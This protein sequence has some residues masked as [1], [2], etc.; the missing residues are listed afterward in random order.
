M[1][2][3]SL[4]YE[5][6][7]RSFAVV[8]VCS[9]HIK[10]VVWKDEFYVYI[11]FARHTRNK[12][13]KKYYSKIQKNYTHATVVQRQRQRRRNIIHCML[14]IA[15]VG[16]CFMHVSVCTA[17]E[18]FYC[19]LKQSL[20]FDYYTFRCI[21]D[22]IINSFESHTATTSIDGKNYIR[23]T[24][25]RYWAALNTYY[26]THW[27]MLSNIVSQHIHFVFFQR[28][29]LVHYTWWR[30]AKMAAGIDESYLCWVNYLVSR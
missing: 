25:F 19:I 27:S 8:F 20:L 26:S 13:K 7:L 17:R 11:C 3:K 30:A 15:A 12:T 29:V 23:P 18:S 9:V 2:D 22:V 4:N 1:K 6:L 24:T 28:N 16:L 5:W 14:I 10:G 21:W